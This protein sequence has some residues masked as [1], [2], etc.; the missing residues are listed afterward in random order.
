MY[1]LQ[2]NY[3]LANAK[4][5]GR[6]SEKSSGDTMKHAIHKLVSPEET[7]AANPHYH[8]YSCQLNWIHS[9]SRHFEIAHC[10]VVCCVLMPPNTDSRVSPKRHFK[11]KS[12]KVI[13][14][15]CWF[16]TLLCI[17]SCTGQYVNEFRML[18]VWPAAHSKWE[19][20]ERAWGGFGV[21][22][23]DGTQEL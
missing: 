5:A 19:E 17:H 9:V 20:R 6:I 7:I 18:V 11:A 23:R 13:E 21:G 16:R 3:R 15:F 10:R 2:L 22:G 12:R 14:L 4:V 8:L 1:S